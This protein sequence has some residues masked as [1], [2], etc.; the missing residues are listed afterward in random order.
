MF[1][2]SAEHQDDSMT[3][4]WGSSGATEHTKYCHGQ[5]D[6]LHPKTLAKLK[7]LKEGKIHETLEINKLKVKTELMKP[8]KF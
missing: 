2:Q 5:L 3:R 4:K 8:V 6:W 1:T 7:S